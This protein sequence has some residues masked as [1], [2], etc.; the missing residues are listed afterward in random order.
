MTISITFVPF[1]DIFSILTFLHVLTHLCDLTNVKTHKL[2]F[3][4]FNT[5]GVCREVKRLA[6]IMVCV[7]GVFVCGVRVV[8]LVSVICGIF[9]CNHPFRV[10]V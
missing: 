2:A 5:I 7:S 6:D 10:Q 1:R 3:F 8:C 9:G 4:N